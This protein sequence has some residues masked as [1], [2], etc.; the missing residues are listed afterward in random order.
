MA[1]LDG[2]NNGTAI[3]MNTYEKWQEDQLC[4]YFPVCSRC[5]T[6]ANTTKLIAK[7]RFDCTRI[8]QQGKSLI[9]SPAA[10]GHSW[11]RLAAD[12]PKLPGE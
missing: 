11:Y 2:N 3:S 12:R 8:F 6:N 9:S 5:H 10:N 7:M 1:L 4:W